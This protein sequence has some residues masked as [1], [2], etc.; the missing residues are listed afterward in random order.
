LQMI[1]RLH[2]RLMAVHVHRNTM[3]LFGCNVSPRI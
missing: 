2:H 1:L 3:D